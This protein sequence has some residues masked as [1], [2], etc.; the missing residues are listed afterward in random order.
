M[1]VGSNIVVADGELPI[2]EVVRAS[3]EREGHEVVEARDEGS[4]FA[5]RGDEFG[6]RGARLW[7]G[8][9]AARVGETSRPRAAAQVS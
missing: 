6:Q 4:G 1:T 2:G 8:R 9:L 7:I 3:I 5:D